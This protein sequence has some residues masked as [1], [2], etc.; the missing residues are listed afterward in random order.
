MEDDEPGARLVVELEEIQFPAE[1]AV[2]ALFR[3]FEKPQMLR[4]APPWRRKAGPV[5]ALEHLVAFVA[6]PVGAGH[7]EE[8]E[9]L[10]HP[11]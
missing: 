4:P 8:L 11:R 5:D 9:G 7:V 3:L 1:T 6:P 10:D 2:V